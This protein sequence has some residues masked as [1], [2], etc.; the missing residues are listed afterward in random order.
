[1]SKSAT[2]SLDEIF[3]KRQFSVRKTD[4]GDAL[5]K[6][7]KAPATFDA[8]NRTAD[9]VMTAE[10]A[11]RYGDIVVAKGGDLKEFE[12][13]PVALWAHNS[14]DFPIG[15]WEN[16]KN[17][18][19][20]PKRLEGTLRLSPEDTTENCDKVFK[21]LSAGLVRACS[22][23]F[24]PKRWESIKDEKDRWIGY[25]FLEWELLECSVCSIPA[26]PAALAKA[27]GEDVGLSLQAIELVLDGWART[28]DGLIVPREEYEKAYF[29]T[30]NK[31]ISI[32]EVRAIEDKPEEKTTATP[33]FEERMETMFSRFFDGFA[34]VFAKG[35]AVVKEKPL[36]LPTETIVEDQQEKQTEDEEVDETAPKLADA[37]T[38]RK[39]KEEIALL[40]SEED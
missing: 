29:A 16:L 33:D 25:R 19:G 8:D 26:N 11:D 40:L 37:D 30:R 14:R 21:L 35:D 34:K 38:V 4:G 20:T 39:Q 27:A 5:T 2:P 15:T 18:N 13:N 17:V 23:G 24:M 3:S 1:M 28:P 10:V 7:Y 31:D 36:E 9:F 12:K 32:H 6:I 22:I